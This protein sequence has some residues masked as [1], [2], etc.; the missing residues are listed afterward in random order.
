MANTSAGSASQA[1]V[2]AHDHLVHPTSK[3]AGQDAQGGAKP[4]GDK[5]AHQPHE[6][7]YPRPE[8]QPTQ[9]IAGLKVRT[10]GDMQA[11]PLHPEGW[12]EVFRARHR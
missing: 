1:S 2:R 11:P 3:I 12:S 5:C 9:H 7:R 4:A 10:Q 8:D 6:E